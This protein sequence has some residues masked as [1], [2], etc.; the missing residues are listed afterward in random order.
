ML[1]RGN[2]RQWDLVGRM[3]SESLS[4]GGFGWVGR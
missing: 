3:R 2:V 4:F 1:G